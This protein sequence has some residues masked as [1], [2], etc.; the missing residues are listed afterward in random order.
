MAQSYGVNTGLPYLGFDPIRSKMRAQAEQER[1]AEVAFRNSEFEATA[2]PEMKANAARTPGGILYSIQGDPRG[3][4]AVPVTAAER[5]NDQP[6]AVVN[7][8][9]VYS[10]MW[11]YA[12]DRSA[13]VGGRAHVQD[14]RQSFGTAEPLKGLRRARGGY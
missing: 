5:F 2:S 6:H 14:E 8:S 10:K 1:Q 13:A 9:D 11:N 4:D 12:R 3:M 7:P